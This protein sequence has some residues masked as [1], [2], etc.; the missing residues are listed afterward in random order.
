MVGPADVPYGAE[1]GRA[2]K[3]KLREWEWQESKM[4]VS[5]IET[6]KGERFGRI[7]G[8]SSKRNKRHIW[9]VSG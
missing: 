2:R 3:P 1:E 6:S 8:R 5:V 9:L 7:E 4:I